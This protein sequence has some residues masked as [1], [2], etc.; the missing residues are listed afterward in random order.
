MAAFGA[1]RDRDNSEGDYI[2][3]IDTAVGGD[4]LI[5]LFVYCD[6]EEDRKF[7]RATATSKKF[8]EDV[9]NSF[10]VATALQGCQLL[11]LDGTTMSR[12]VRKA[13]KLN[14]SVPQLVLIDVDGKILFK[15]TASTGSD[16]LAKMIT[17][18][19]DRCAEIVADR[20]EG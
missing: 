8:E 20:S 13:Y 16:A 6:N 15:A 14:S 4:K 11:K 5:V 17:A 12:D 9:L 7:A 2:E 19:K 10:P 18:A 1:R 3:Q